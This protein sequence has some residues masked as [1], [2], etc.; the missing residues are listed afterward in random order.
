M[1]SVDSSPLPALPWIF[2]LESVPV[3]L[4]ATKVTSSGPLLFFSGGSG[5]SS[6]CGIS[7]NFSGPIA[8]FNGCTTTWSGLITTLTRVETWGRWSLAWRDSPQPASS[9]AVP[10]SA[11][12]AAALAPPRP[13]RGLNL[14]EGEGD[15]F[16]RNAIFTYGD[17]RAGLRLA[18]QDRQADRPEGGGEG[19]A[20]DR[21]D[22]LLAEDEALARLRRAA[23]SQSPQVA[24]G[25]ALVVEAGDR[26]LTDV[27]AL[28]E[29]DRLLDDPGLGGHRLGPHL[30]SEAGT[31]GLDSHD[32]RRLGGDLDGAGV[33]QRRVDAVALGNGDDQVDAVVDAERGGLDRPRELG[34]PGAD[35]REEDVLVA[36]VGDLDLAADLVHPQVAAG[37]RQALRL[38]VEPQLRPLARP[39]HP[40]VGLH[41]ALAV[42]QSSVGP[43]TR[44]NRLGVIGQLALQIVRRVRAAD[45]QQATVR[46]LDQPAF[47]AQLPVLGV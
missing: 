21:P 41:V 15:D 40:H 28:G 30:G 38:E 17:R 26:L 11:T 43:L 47:F 35:Q 36:G 10:T 16:S 1:G 37:R 42:E 22:L 46:P 31:A 23:E 45:D 4:E 27:A 2:N 7:W 5:W 39:Q 18:A 12:I 33:E 24:V 14:T 9:A 13:I 34:R 32:L 20:A 19:G 25:L 44:L 29:A 8:I 6:F 3:W